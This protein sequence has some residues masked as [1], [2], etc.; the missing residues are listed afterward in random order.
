MGMVI[1]FT[2]VTPEALD[3]AIEDPEWAEAH[4]DD[5]D[6]TDEPDG[7]IDKAWAGIQFLLDAAD[8]PINLRENGEFIGEEG[9]FFGWSA[10]MVAEA[11]RHLR[12]TPFERLAP[13]FDPAQMTEQ[14]IYPSAIWAR[15]GGELD[16]LR[17]HY[18]QLVRFFDA[19]ATSGSAAIMSFSF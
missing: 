16:Y 5:L 18:E 17:Q 8:V 11:A 7:Y 6:T 10:F 12:A 19:A 4:L 3:K 14:D 1:S 9:Y 13:H 2:R 15:N